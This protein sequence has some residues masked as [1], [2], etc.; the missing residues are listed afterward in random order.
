MIILFNQNKT[1]YNDIGYSNVCHILIVGAVTNNL[2]TSFH[3]SK[4]YNKKK[5]AVEKITFLHIITFILT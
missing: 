5:S 2:F 4:N 1:Q 3:F